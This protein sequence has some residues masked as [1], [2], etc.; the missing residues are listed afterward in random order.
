MLMP[1]LTSITFRKLSSADI[2]KLAVDS[3]IRA[4]EWGSDI[5]V[6]IGDLKN[7]QYVRSMCEDA[8]ITICSYGTYCNLEDDVDFQRLFMT[9]NELGTKTLRIWAGKLSSES[10]TDSYKNKIVNNAIIM[11]EQ[12]AKHGLRLGFEFHRN[13]LTDSA[14]STIW[15]LKQIAKNNVSTYWQ[16][17]IGA[18]LSENLKDIDLLK[19]YLSNIHV[20]YWS[21]DA[22][23]RYLL[24]EGQ[25]DWQS[26]FFS[27]NDEKIR[28]CLIEFVKDD[29]IKCLEEDALTLNQLIKK[30]EVNE[31]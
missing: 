11:A 27:L 31:K 26:Y 3:N 5:H 1:G 13:T 21:S 16:P 9:A 18:T 29:N 30:L 17:R 4:I 23:I 7:A 10:A 8:G 22:S 14:E 20:F 28:Y 15:L 2:V 12:A 19:P 25:Q 24:R 6:P